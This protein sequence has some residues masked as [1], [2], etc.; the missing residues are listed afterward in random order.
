[1]NESLIHSIFIIFKNAIFL[2]INC[3]INYINMHAF[4]GLLPAAS[5]SIAVQLAVAY[6]LSCVR[7]VCVSV[8][9]AQVLSEGG[10]PLT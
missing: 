3:T 9:V 4:S 8:C 5:V 2:Q 6:I 1:M 10:L 7:C